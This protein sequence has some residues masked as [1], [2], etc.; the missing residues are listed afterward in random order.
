MIHGK[1]GNGPLE[2]VMLVV[3]IMTPQLT[4]HQ[5]GYLGYSM[6]KKQRKE[7]Y[8]QIFETIAEL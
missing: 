6:T 3:S 2:R 1:I 4:H 7:V 8:I 5:D